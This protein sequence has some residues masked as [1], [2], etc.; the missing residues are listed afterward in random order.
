MVKVLE[1]V[2]LYYRQK[3][4]GCSD[5]GLCNLRSNWLRGACFNGVKY[6]QDTFIC[7]PVKRLVSPFFVIVLTL[8]VERFTVQGEVSRHVYCTC[9]CTSNVAL[10][11][12]DCTCGL[13]SDMWCSHLINSPPQKFF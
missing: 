6:P 2:V 7:L 11:T 1:F 12:D 10:M 13:L 8:V 9:T 3:H 4:F 5:D